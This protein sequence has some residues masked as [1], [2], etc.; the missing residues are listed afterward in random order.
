MNILE[1]NEKKRALYNDA[2]SFTEENIKIKP[3]YD[4]S[5]TL[6]VE[7]AGTLKDLLDD[8]Y[9]EV[10][11]LTLT[12]NLNRGDFGFIGTMSRDYTLLH[13]DISKANIVYE[14]EKAYHSF[15]LEFII[16][17]DNLTASENF[18]CWSWDRIKEFSISEN[19]SCYATI[20]GV[21]FSKDK[22]TLIHYPCK[23]TTTS[24]VI[25]NGVISIGKCAFCRC[26]EIES[27]TMPN[28]VTEIGWCAFCG[29]E[30]LNAITIG[31]G[32]TSIGCNAFEGCT[33]LTS[34]TISNS[35]ISIGSG[36]FC[37]C[38]GL[39]SIT[40]PNSVE[41]IGDGAFGCKQLTAIIIGNSVAS[42]GWYAFCCCSEL[43]EIHSNNPIP[44]ICEQ[45]VVFSDID[46]ASCKLYVPV[47]SYDAYSKAEGWKEFKSI[48]EIDMNEK[49]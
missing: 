30:K 21:L 6:H 46:K 33:G 22:A 38:T 40:I 37:A 34:V 48:I 11:H 44:P 42:I 43:K 24:Y 8:N 14:E 49:N 17:P 47:G 19:N 18:A 36:A 7:T 20:D 27:I 3:K 39:T 1:E 26:T 32:V 45:E 41:S 9:K 15:D 5:L 35:V 29:C 12:G 10:T 25:P 4:L 28:S 2:D 31:N 16:L 23:K 13:L